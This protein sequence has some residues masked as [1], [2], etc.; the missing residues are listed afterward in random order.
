MFCARDTS[1][2]HSK[3]GT[4]EALTASAGEPAIHCI[5]PKCKEQQ[6]A[7]RAVLQGGKTCSEHNRVQQ[8]KKMHHD[9]GKT[10]SIVV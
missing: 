2:L 7:A 1:Q 3:V 9:V 8:P 5:N 10:C 4:K 6:R